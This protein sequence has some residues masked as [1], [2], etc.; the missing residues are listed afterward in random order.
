M[1][2][3]FNPGQAF[4]PPQ[5]RKAEYALFIRPVGV[6]SGWNRTFLQVV[7]YIACDHYNK[8]GNK[9]SESLGPSI[10]L[11]TL[12]VHCKTAGG[13]SGTCLLCYLAGLLLSEVPVLADSVKQLAPLHHLHNK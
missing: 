3:G 9:I 6:Y 8:A 1:Y 12:I 11:S 10:I 2:T 4:S 5:A 13:N 7:A